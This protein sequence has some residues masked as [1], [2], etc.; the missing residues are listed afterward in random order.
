MRNTVFSSI[1]LGLVLV[2]PV[3]SSGLDGLF[4]S[5]G[6][7]L[8]GGGT[9]AAGGVSGLT[10]AQIDAGLKQALSLGTERAV[11][12]L[13]QPGGFLNDPQ[14][15]I[16]LPG[17]LSTAA[18]GLRA[19][20]QGRY[21]DDFENTVN[22]A[23]ERAIPETLEIVQQTVADMSL[24]DVRG[25]LTGPDDAATQYLRERAGDDL[26]A[27]VLPIVQQATEA[28]GATSAYKALVAQSG[29]M[30]GGLGGL[31]GL[32]GTDSLDLDRYVTNETLDGLFVK[33]A[34]EEKRI[35]QDPVA[36]TTDLLETVFSN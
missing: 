3:M 17:M 31:G 36:R 34:A 21:V 15:R 11:A 9:E 18:E 23:A 2:G 27:A 8:Q 30:L 20:G 13:G 35:R 28:A 1:L 22:R 7:L 5:A 26:F 19:A 16:P 6:D 4:K 29:G 33:L 14:V 12:L 10:D 24:Q 32:L 25:I